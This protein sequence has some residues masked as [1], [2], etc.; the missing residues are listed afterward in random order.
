M[1]KIT[2]LALRTLPPNARLTDDAIEGF[3][4][5]C[6]PSGRVSFGYQY[7]D[8]AT[9]KRRWMG[10]GLHGNV[11]VDEARDQAKRFAG[12]VAARRDPAAELKVKTARSTNTVDHLLD[13]WLKLHVDVECR[14]K[15]AIKQIL[16]NHVRP[17]L[18]DKIIYDLARGDLMRLVDEL[19]LKHPRMAQVVLSHLRS[20]FNWWQLRD[21]KFASP[22]VRGMVKDKKVKRL[23]VLTGEELA[24]IW[25]ALDGRIRRVSDCFAPFVK[26]L[27]LT[28]GRRNEVAQMHTREFD[29]DMWTIPPTRYKTNIEHVVPLIPEIRKFLPK[30]FGYVFSCD[31]GKT[32]VAGL[33]KQKVKLDCMIAKIREREGR[34][35]MPAWTFHDLRR[36]ART[37]MAELKID[38]DTAEACLGH[39][40]PGVEGIYNRYKYLPEKTVALEKLAAHVERL[41]E[42]RP[43]AAAAKLRLV[44]G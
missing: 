28:A 16:A 22:I 18:G 5:R 37:M 20:A 4:A 21:E 6:L 27:L 12:Q 15:V 25:A 17:A 1:T 7:T 34:P 26:V 42:P 3:V 2:E 29:G 43:P 23:R 14:G 9:G 40:R 24:D 19:G 39:T 38:R 41:V 36:T 32:P 11:T 33:H 31:G 8:K 30:T 44:A 10:I 13:E 35:M